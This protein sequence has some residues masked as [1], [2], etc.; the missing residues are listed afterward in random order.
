MNNIYTMSKNIYRVTK[1]SDLDEIIKN[2]FLKPIF[3]VFLN[4][5]VPANMFEEVAI[6]LKTMAKK[7][8]YDMFLIINLD[9]FI[10]NIN[11]YDELKKIVPCFI[12]Y[13][14]GKQVAFIEDKQNFLPVITNVIE[15]I[16]DN[17]MS[18]LINYFQ[19]NYENN[20]QPRQIPV[21]VNTINN[22]QQSGVVSTVEPN[23]MNQV[24]QNIEENN[25]KI[26]KNQKENVEKQV[27]ENDDEEEEEDED[28]DEEEEDDDIKEKVTEKEEDN[29]K[30]INNIKKRTIELEEKKVEVKKQDEESHD[31]DESEEIR[32]KKEKLKQLLKM[33]QMLEK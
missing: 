12:S 26:I 1:K 5:S 11:F 16:N 28:D 9:K 30:V 2:N 15:K 25:K 17:Y 10:D 4:D 24:T 3:I 13:F 27:K 6:T 23:G 19:E 31:D 22:P 8:T 18:R 32:K 20:Q 21:E 33:K 29:P 7:N 14:K